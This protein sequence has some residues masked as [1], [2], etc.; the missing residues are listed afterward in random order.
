M[1]E[2]FNPLDGFR[3]VYWKQPD[4]AVEQLVPISELLRIRA[5]A[6]LEAIPRIKA[7]A[8]REVAADIRPGFVSGRWDGQQVA[9]Y[10]ERRAQ[11]VGQ[12]TVGG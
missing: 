5:E 11:R 1:P 12:E 9:E 7:E 2:D 4:G 6:L 3:S 10:L 8:L